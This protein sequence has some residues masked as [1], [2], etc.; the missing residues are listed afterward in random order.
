M[1]KKLSLIIAFSAFFFNFVDAGNPREYDFDL[2]FFRS[3]HYCQWAFVYEGK[4]QDL[5]ASIRYDTMSASYK[6]LNAKYIL[7]KYTTDR[8]KDIKEVA[9]VMISG[10]DL[11][12]ARNNELL[13]VLNSAYDIDSSVPR[14]IQDELDRIRAQKKEGLEKVH[15]AVSRFFS[16]NITTSDN[17]QKGLIKFKLSKQQRLSLLKRLDALFEG[18][19]KWHSFNKSLEEAYV[20]CG[21]DL[22]SWLIFDLNGLRN[23]LIADT[24]EETKT[25][26]MLRPTG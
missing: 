19:L 25:K 23:F 10:I 26:G 6:L 12:L 16:L 24:F 20:K 5:P 21:A 18:L 14:N 1:G 7:L 3:L 13:S 11:L 4:R 2:D 22:N 8:D 9:G 15:I 17:K